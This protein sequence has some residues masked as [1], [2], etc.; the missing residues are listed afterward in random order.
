MEN[1]NLGAYVKNSFSVD[2]LKSLSEVAAGKYST[3]GDSF[4]C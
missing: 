4:E 3:Y 2:R 1:G